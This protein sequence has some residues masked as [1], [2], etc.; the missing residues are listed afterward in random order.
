MAKSI[1][2]F[3]RYLYPVLVLLIMMPG[4][5]AQ[6][7]DAPWWKDRPLRIYHPNMRELEAEDF[8]VER[9]I[10]DCKALYAE[11]IVFSVGGPYAFYNTKVPYH[12]KSPH[13]GDRDL[14]QEVIQEAK[15][16]KIRV[17]A[18]LD[19]S[20]SNQGVLEEKPEWFFFDQNGNLSEKRSATGEQFFR[21]NLLEAYRNEAFAFPVLQEVCSGYKI[22]GVHLN[23]PGFRS[24]HFNKET[25]EK[26]SIPEDPLAQKRWREER[27][28]SQMKEYRHII[29]SN[30]PDALFMAEINSPENPGWGEGRSFNHEL[31]AGSYT[32]LLS[33]AGEPVD[34]ELYKLRWWSALSADWSHA[35][36][37][38]HSGLPLI[39]LKV[40][41]QKGKL[42]LK[43][44]NDY[45]LNCYQAFAHNAGIKAPSYGL[46]GN[47]PDPR[48][49]SMIAEPFQFMERCEVFMTGSEKIAPVALVW[50]AK[51]AEGFNVASYRNEM[52][53]L[54]RALVKEHVLFEIILA[55]RL[56][57][58]L[59]DRHHTLIVPSLN[60]IEKEQ[61][62]SL[63]SFVE[64]GGHLI[65]FDAFPAKPLSLEWTEFLGLEQS[66]E[67]YSTAY[68]VSRQP[69]LSTLPAAIMLNTDLR[70]VI[71]PE[72]AEILYFNSPSPGGSWVPEAFPL[73]ENGDIPVLFSMKKAR[74]RVSYF[75]GSLGT[76]MWDND[77]P[78]YGDIL[79][80]LVFEQISSKRIIQTDAPKTVD[81]TAYRTGP[82]TV[83]HLVNGTGS[84]PLAEPVPVGP[85]RIQIKDTSA[86]RCS[87]FEPGKIGKSDLVFKKENG[88]LSTTIENLNDYGIV[89]IDSE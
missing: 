20:I 53:G 1:K 5:S 41:Y 26:F 74:G 87:W 10:A 66:G 36:K 42:S 15:M 49:A 85:I 62:E 17:V 67:P 35:S 65:L 60:I 73:L 28:A 12:K 89:V 80:H 83:I 55:H 34:E 7:D 9:F 13:M 56:K 24:S 81:I 71:P 47:M 63:Q 64:S 21:T 43:P 3:S 84:I 52:L 57:E 45:K 44:F 86:I 70:R 19:F 58:D 29:H 48:T 79:E 40:G 39:N 78:D 54:Y 31:L 11:A 2:Q 33:T 16:A 59:T 22:D 69:G 25:I 32:N 46:M 27:L 38:E 30:N 8:D 6:S 18:R 14:L 77:L 50:P 51:N 75:A 88:I 23:A 76:M 72:G 82:Y 61:T 68:A 4:I 37:S